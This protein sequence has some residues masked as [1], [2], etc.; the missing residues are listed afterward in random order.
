MEKRNL[1]KNRT[2]VVTSDKAEKTISVLVKRR[3]KHVKYGKFVNKQKKYIAHDENNDANIGDTV[4]ITET[5]PLSKNKT[6][7]LEKIIERAK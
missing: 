3:L 2:G 5:R 7:R 1:R 6:W 4:R